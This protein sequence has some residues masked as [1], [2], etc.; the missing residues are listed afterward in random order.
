MRIADRDMC[1][2][3]RWYFSMFWAMECPGGVACTGCAGC[4]W[5]VFLDFWKD[6]GGW[7]RS[8]TTKGR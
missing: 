7:Y 6:L 8:D 2:G 4:Y 5:D 3:A 1:G